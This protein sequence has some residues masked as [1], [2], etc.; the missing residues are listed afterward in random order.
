SEAENMGRRSTRA[1]AAMVTGAAAL[2]LVGAACVPPDGGDPTTTTTSTTST[3]LPS[4][5]PVPGVDLPDVGGFDND[6]DG[7]DGDAEAA[8]AVSPD[9]SD[10]ASGLTP[11]DAVA[12]VGRAIDVAALTPRSQVLVAAGDVEEE[13]G[14]QLATGVGLYG[15]YS[16]D[17]RTRPG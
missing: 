15:G 9:G 17:F 4:C 16:A 6:C 7:I 13:P 2:A 11:A 14:A 8:V 10:E 5:D 12:T 1:R 3:T